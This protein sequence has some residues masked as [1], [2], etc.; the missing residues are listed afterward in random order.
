LLRW[1]VIESVTEAVIAVPAGSTSGAAATVGRAGAG[2][3][4]TGSGLGFWGFG[5][6]G[7]GVCLG[8]VE[9]DGWAAGVCCGG[10]IVG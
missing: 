5:V 8:G 7:R 6:A 4:T 10:V 1:D 3:L 2:S 9:V